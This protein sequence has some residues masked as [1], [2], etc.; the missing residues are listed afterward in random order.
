M[1]NKIGIYAG[2]FDPFTVGHLNI[3][4]QAE[5]LFGEGN[6]IIAVGV[7]PTKSE[8]KKTLSQRAFKVE[9]QL[10]DKHVISYECFIHELIYLLQDKN[11]ENEYWLVRGLRSGED[12]LQETTQLKFIQDMLGNRLNS[13]F[14]V[15]DKEF[16][17]ISS[18]AVRM[19]EAVR[20]GEGL[21][22]LG[23]TNPDY[24]VISHL[25]RDKIQLASE[26]DTGDEVLFIGKYESCVYFVEKR[27][28]A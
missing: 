2:S 23:K 14:F 20:P 7:N 6:V 13:V 12:L 8:S 9:K 28:K 25:G 24:A 5:N 18:S 4:E 27:K 15:C 16:E 19:I 1:K 26:E 21:V 11:P 10:P 17:H 22:Y 3:L